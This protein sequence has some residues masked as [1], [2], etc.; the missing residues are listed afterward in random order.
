M[1]SKPDLA[2][3]LKTLRLSAMLDTLPERIALARREQLDYPAFLEIILT[4]E[5]N[6]REHRRIENRL[7]RAGFEE[8]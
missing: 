6:R 5:A 2:P 8:T 7:N 3:L 4:D 1:T